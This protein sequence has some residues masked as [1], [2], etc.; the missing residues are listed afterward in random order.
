MKKIFLVLAT[1]LTAQIYS[2]E[3]VGNTQFNLVDRMAIKNVI[4]AYGFYWDTNQL[5]KWMAL[6]TDDAID[7]RFLDKKESESKIKDNYAMYQ[8]RMKYFIK[9]KMQRRHMMANTLFVKQTQST[10]TIEQ[11]TTLLTTNSG[12]KTAI[13]SPIFYRFKLQKIDGIWKINYRQLLLD[14]KLDLPIK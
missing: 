11:Y 10:A 12:S 8:E 6:F 9:N 5:E 2:Q 14:K 4:D 3:I 7:S 1:F 13:V